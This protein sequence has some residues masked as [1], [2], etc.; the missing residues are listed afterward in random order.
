MGQQSFGILITFS[1]VGLIAFETESVIKTF[2][3]GSCFFDKLG[4]QFLESVQFAFVNLEVGYDG[5]RFVLGS[6]NDLLY[7]V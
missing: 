3:L 4:T 7:K 1:A 5:T 6:H 2:R